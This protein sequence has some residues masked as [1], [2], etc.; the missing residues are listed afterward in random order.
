MIVS[1]P[2]SKA[3]EYQYQKKMH[4]EESEEYEEVDVDCNNGD[5]LVRNSKGEPV[6]NNQENFE[7]ADD[8]FQ[9][10]SEGAA[11]IL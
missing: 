1:G 5:A 11:E 2:F 9:E 10:P 7:E 4:Q 6:Y 8:S 3:A